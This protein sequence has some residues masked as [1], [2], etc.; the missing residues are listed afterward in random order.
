[1][2]VTV[3]CDAVAVFP[4]PVERALPGWSGEHRAWTEANAAG[5]VAG[6]DWLLHFHAYL[7][8]AD[9]TAILVDTGIGPAGSPASDWLGTAGRLPDVLAGAGVTPDE[10]GT[11]VLT[12]V[13]L[14][15]VGWNHHFANAAYVVQQAEV[16]H[17]RGTAA[18][19]RY[20]E[21]IAGQLR[22]VAGRTWLEGVTVIPAPGHTPGHQVVA[23]GNEILAGDVLVHPAQAEWP[24]LAYVY[25]TDPEEAADSRRKVLAMG[26]PV[27][28]AHVSC[29]G[30]GGGRS[31]RR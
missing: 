8:T 14:D 27:L 11:V 23:T 4:E 25:E 30:G 15:H 31:S 9:S 17:L 12:H 28:P 29:D 21:P 2:D 26:M 16:D 6:G 1:V 24:E 19:R 13:H 20:L 18:Y 10:I 3:L 5:N 22:I 7:L